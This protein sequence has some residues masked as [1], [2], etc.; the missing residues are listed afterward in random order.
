MALGCATH[1]YAVVDRDGGLVAASGDLT[2]VQWSR[3]LNDASTASVT[4]GVSGPGCCAQLG[5]IRSWRHWLNIYRNDD[6]V[7]AGPILNAD[8]SFDKVTID[9]VDIIG[10]LDRRVPHQDFTFTDTDITEIARQL[11]ED[12]LAPDDPGHTT[13]VIGAAGVTGGREYEKDIGQT[14]DHLRD[15][16]DTGL[17]FTAVGNNVVILPDDFCDVVGRLADEDLP[18][19]LT[20][21]EDGAS[22][23][24]R[25]V[26]AGSDESGAVG[27]A[28]GTNSYYGLLERYTQQSTI[29]SQA[30][31]DTAAAARLKA[32]LAVPVF[33]DTQ[34]VTLSPTA[35]VDI[36]KLVPGWCVDITT[37]STCRTITQ[38][39]KI[40]G[41]TVSEDG[42]SEDT[43]GQEKV[44]LQVSATGDQLEVT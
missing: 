42:G 35:N 6:F 17:D 27:T 31:A 19:G 12:G 40:T 14:A 23:A 8:W 13:T 3:V 1:T 18:E 26:V 41:L 16:A 21:S 33:I 7:W 29:T 10:L 28:G 11:V 37:D 44:L 2:A 30:A 22:L 34:N 24:T 5:N 4:I 32:M 9:A 15:L 20:V 43:P 39:L 36:A 25:V 38:Q